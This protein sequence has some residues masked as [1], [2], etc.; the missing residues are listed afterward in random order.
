MLLL[1]NT[2]NNT[3]CIPRGHILQLRHSL[4]AAGSILQ[5]GPLTP[6]LWPHNFVLVNQVMF[7]PNGAGEIVAPTEHS[8]IGECLENLSLE[9]AKL[10]GVFQLPLSGPTSQNTHSNCLLVTLSPPC[11]TP[12]G[13][14]VVKRS[15]R[16]KLPCLS[17]R[18]KL[19]CLAAMGRGPPSCSSE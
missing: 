9:L 12:D 15:Q 17:T 13:S 14:Y 3:E 2:V 6:E 8:I 11:R 4:Q 16:L 7:N 18:L 5:T 10:T 1:I 19:P